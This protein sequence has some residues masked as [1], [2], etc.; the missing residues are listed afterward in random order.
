MYKFAGGQINE[1]MHQPF[2]QGVGDARGIRLAYEQQSE[3]YAQNKQENA[4][5][6][7]VLNHRL[8]HVGGNLDREG[9][10]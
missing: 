6:W 4:D 9:N 3:C 1:S 10:R 2:T 5:H 7:R 8:G